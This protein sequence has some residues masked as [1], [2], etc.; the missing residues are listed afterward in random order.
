MVRSLRISL[1]TTLLAIANIHGQDNWPQF[2]GPNAAGLAPEGAHLPETWSTTQNVAWKVEIPGR[3]L[4]S[5]IVW[6]DRI[7][8]TSCLTEGKTPVAKKGLYFGGEQFKPPTDLHRWAVYCVDLN[9]G[10]IRWETVVHKGAPKSTHHIKN[11]YASETPVT[12]G[13]RVYAYFGNV[14]IF[15]LDMNG[16]ELWHKDLGVFKTR[17]GWGTAA[18]P[19]LHQDRLYIVNDNEEKSFLIALNKKT[20][21]EIW[22]VDRPDEK[23]N[24]ATPFIWENELRT[25]I[26]TCGSGSV[27]SYDL[28]GKLLWELKGLSSITIPTPITRFGLLYLGSGYV[29]EK[30]NFKPLYAIRPGASGDISLGKEESSNAYVV[31]RQKSAAPYNPSFLIYGDYLYVLKDMGTLDCY[32]AR[33]GKEIYKGQRIGPAANAFTSSPWAYADKVFCLSEDGDTFAVQAG[34]NFKLLGKN[35]LG[36]MTLTTPALTKDSL[37]IRTDTKLYRIREDKS[38]GVKK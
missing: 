30:D 17:F 12:D 38:A 19:V 3:G 2:R 36:E 21:Q 24:W 6:G 9:A 1:V 14:G 15:C 20:G 4:S 35:S 18:S 16:K 27:R 31:W 26:I 25:E 33:T 23:S 5:P 10:K 28:N 13:E 37:I 34:P 29:L 32:D 11:S 7:F 22:R 8:V